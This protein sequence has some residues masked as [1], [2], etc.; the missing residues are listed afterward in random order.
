MN[1]VRDLSPFTLVE[2][3]LLGWQQ[4]T[5]DDGAFSEKDYLHDIPYFFFSSLTCS[6]LKYILIR[7]LNL[8]KVASPSHGSC[9][10]VF[11]DHVWEI[12]SLLRL[13]SP[14]LPQAPFIPIVKYM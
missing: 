14:C 9:R 4:G 8:Y 2:R 3:D 13:L 11:V 6:S 1:Q 10:R 5:S 7:Y 12:N